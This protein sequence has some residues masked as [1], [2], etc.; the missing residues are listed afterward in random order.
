[1]SLGLQVLAVPVLIAVNAFFVVAEYA[2]VA[3]RT[4]QIE[5]L[6]KKSPGAAEALRVLKSRMSSTIGT[7]QICITMTNLMLGSLGEPAMTQVLLMLFKG[8]P[9]GPVTQG[10]SITLSFVIVTLLTVV[11]SEMVPKALTLQYTLRLAALI[12]RPILL[13]QRLLKPLVW[14]MD[15]SANLTTRL[16]GL[17]QVNIADTGFT[18][19]ELRHIASDAAESGNL[20]S[21]ERSL[22]LNSLTLGR[23]AAVE[24]MVPR[25]RVSYLD[26]QRS[27]K[28]NLDAISQY[29]FSR[30]PL[31]DGGM[32][33][34]VG[35]VYTKEFLT[36]V[37]ETE[38]DSSVLL[39]ISRPPVFAPVTIPLDKLLTR[40]H[41][42]K[43][44]LIFLV[45]EHGSVK[46]IVTLTDVVNELLG[47]M[48]EGDD[49]RIITRTD[50]HLIV[51]GE[52]P[53]SHLAA[54]LNC[55]EWKPETE[56]HSVGGL[57][58]DRLGRVPR[59]GD[60]V[61]VDRWRFVAHKCNGRT[62]EEVGI[63]FDVPP[64]P[65]GGSKTA[66]KP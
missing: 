48:H 35:V 64:D 42:D 26:L 47:P 3:I 53:I 37:E 49:N 63:Y 45:D 29:L 44:H 17:G 32:D 23:R 13:I 19:E 39:L 22:I 28:E 16:L 21:Q 34:V 1:M 66:P 43:T 27:M 15:T 56:A 50:R 59:Q 33:H 62:V 41:D 57:L 55:P 30:M 60:Q 40:F 38:Q 51:R 20:T 18:V 2:L 25:M 10:V 12:A 54:H 6:R 5:E 4:S 9:D 58:V 11:L 24:I 7:V 65:S 31:C 61:M 36:A 46:G 52:M 14:V 8:L